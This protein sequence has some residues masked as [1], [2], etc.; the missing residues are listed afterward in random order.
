MAQMLIGRTVFEE[1][2]V[3]KILR[4]WLSF[5]LLQTQDKKIFKCDLLRVLIF[6]TKKNY[7]N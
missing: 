1:N 2:F 7:L 3:Y 6:T 5:N 4:K